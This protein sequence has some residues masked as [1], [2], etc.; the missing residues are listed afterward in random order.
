[1]LPLYKLSIIAVVTPLAGV[2]IEIA[3]YPDKTDPNYVTPLAGVW[4]EI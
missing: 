1:M 2:W 4:I 3:A